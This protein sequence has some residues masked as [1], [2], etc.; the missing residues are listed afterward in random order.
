MVWALKSLTDD[1]ELEP[2]LEALPELVWGSNGRRR[3]NENMLSMLLESD[4]RLIPRIEALLRDSDNGLLTPDVQLRRRMFCIKALWALACFSV[5]EA[6]GRQSFPVFDHTLLVSLM[7]STNIVG[8]L[9]P[10]LT[11][12]YAMVRCSDFCSLSMFIRGVSENRK[13]SPIQVKQV[14]TRAADLSFPAFSG[15]LEQLIDSDW[16]Q[17]SAQQALDAMNSCADLAYDILADYWRRSATVQQMAYQFEATSSLIQ[18]VASRPSAVAIMQLKD[19]F[20]SLIDENLTLI[21]QYRTF[22]PLDTTLD[23][24]LYVFQQNPDYLVDMRLQRLFLSYVAHRP[25]I[26]DVWARMFPT[27]DPTFIGCLLTKCLVVLDGGLRDAAVNLMWNCSCWKWKCAIFD[28]A[29][30]V[31]IRG[32]K[33]TFLT[34]CT[35]AALRI[36][37][38]RRASGT[39]PSRHPTL[40]QQQ[41]EDVCTIFLE[42]L[43]SREKFPPS[44]DA[45]RYAETETF[46]L[47]IFYLPP[48]PSFSLTFQRRFANSFSNILNGDS[49]GLRLS[50]LTWVAWGSG[51]PVIQAFDDPD[52]RATILE[53]SR[54]SLTNE[55]IEELEQLEIYHIN[56]LIA[57]LAS[58]NHDSDASINPGPTTNSDVGMDDT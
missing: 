36:E 22:H 34:S 28:D 19:T 47:L 6:S 32:I 2:F 15:A 7:T 11:S 26:P 31:A 41:E 18:Q 44:N 21:E 53:A 3:G 46:K 42:F 9:L 16:T 54:S 56:T 35:I 33:Q 8:A 55:T 39:P 12:T 58:D 14:Q 29:T 52:A 5:S 57:E 37:I 30:V 17:T 20:T 49:P 27:C 38:L 13:I 50:I 24:L 45:Q 23:A 51:S 4:L 40:L 43:D 10:Y 48:T 25:W 1:D